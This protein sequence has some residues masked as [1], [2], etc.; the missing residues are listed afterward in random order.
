VLMRLD[1]GSGN[2]VKL[3]WRVSTLPII[4]RPVIGS[5]A[6]FPQRTRADRSA[7]GEEPGQKPQRERADHVIDLT[8]YHLQQLNEACAHFLC[9]ELDIALTY[10][11]HARVNRDAAS[12]DRAHVAVS[13]ACNTVTAF[14]ARLSIESSRVEQITE[15]VALVQARMRDLEQSAGR[16]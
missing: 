9:T 13:R 2:R 16:V 6:D 1:Q 14:L 7:C 10:I 3:A 8:A 4:P 11:R 12:V 5:L 15:R